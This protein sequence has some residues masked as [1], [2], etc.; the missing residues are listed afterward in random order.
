MLSSHSY[1]ATFHLTIATP[2]EL[3]H[4]CYSPKINQRQNARE[5]CEYHKWNI[6]LRVT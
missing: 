3:F 6:A 5:C 4:P 2:M 1:I